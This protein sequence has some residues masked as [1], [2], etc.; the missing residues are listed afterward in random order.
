MNRFFQELRN[1]F[2][3][4]LAVLIPAGVTFWV[5]VSFAQVVDGVL[6]L[7][8]LQVRVSSTNLATSA[9]PRSCSAPT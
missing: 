8:P 9:T 7:L 1:T 3:A 5:V 6:D 4:G 2:L